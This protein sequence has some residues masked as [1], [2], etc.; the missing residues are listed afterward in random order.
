MP[1]KWLFQRERDC[2]GHLDFFQKGSILNFRN[3]TK[4]RF[5][6]KLRRQPPPT[7]VRASLTC[8]FSQEMSRKKNANK[9]G[10]SEAYRFVK[11]LGVPYKNYAPCSSQPN[12]L[13]NSHTEQ[14]RLDQFHS[15]NSV[16]LKMWSQK[17]NIKNEI[18]S[19]FP[20]TKLQNMIS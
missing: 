5:H 18:E 13:I 8:F 4:I 2:F 12:C 11:R 17:M 9:S 16:Y 19:T 3:A 1:L 6:K 15:N 14:C 20:N 10:E 7:E